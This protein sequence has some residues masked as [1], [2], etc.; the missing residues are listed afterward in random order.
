MSDFETTQLENQHYLADLDCNGR[1]LL[2]EDP[3]IYQGKGCVFIEICPPLMLACIQTG[4]DTF[5]Y[6]KPDELEV[7]V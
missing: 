5:D 1:R 6:V 4:K 7:I 3:V 2:P